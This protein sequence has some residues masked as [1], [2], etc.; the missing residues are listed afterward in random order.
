MGLC[1]GEKEMKASRKWRASFLFTLSGLFSLFI[2][3]SGFTYSAW[4]L[5]SKHSWYLSSLFSPL[6]FF[7]S[8]HFFVLFSSLTF[9]SLFIPIS[10]SSLSFQSLPIFSLFSFLSSSYIKTLRYL[11]IFYF[12]CNQTNPIQSSIH[13]SISNYDSPC[14]HDGNKYE[15]KSS[16][17]YYPSSQNRYE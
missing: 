4:Y 3:G 2:V 8:S 16:S 6:V 17:K 12:L 13:F 14:K 9:L 7:S 1:E 15:S 11:C 5:V 10:F